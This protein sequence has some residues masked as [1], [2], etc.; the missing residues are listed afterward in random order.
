MAEG[1]YTKKR[2]LFVDDEANLLQGLRRMSYLMRAEW[3]MEFAEN[4]T[5]ALALLADAPFDI[6]VSDM[7]MP[8][9]DGAQLLNEVR[10]RYPNIVRIILSGHSDREMILRAAKSSHQYLA[11]PC[12]GETLLATIAR[13]CA[14]RELLEHEDLRRLVTAMQTLPSPPTLYAEVVEAAQSP[15]GSLKQ[16]GEIIHRDMSMTAKILQLVNSG[17]FGLRQRVTTPLQAVSLLGLEIVQMLILSVQIFRTFDQSKLAGLS[18]NTLWRHSAAVGGCARSIAQGESY[19]REMVDHAFIAGLLHDVG[20]VVLA[21]NLPEL[22]KQT[23]VLAQTEKIA[24]EAAERAIFN[25]THAEVGAYLLGL[26]GLPDCIV[27]ALA[28]HHNPRTC[29]H[30][31]FT[32]LTTVHVANALFHEMDV[33]DVDSQ[34]AAIDLDY[35]AQMGLDDRLAFWRERCQIACQ[36]VE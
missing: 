11:K 19:D 31:S 12:D 1:T 35:V 30:Q 8:G 36:P 21:V 25:T 16:I 14:L 29:L 3:D 7:R 9:I 5:Q 18:L 13:S 4:G 10:Q 34:T 6:I 23:L 33:V 24:A 20:K 2:V 32:L 17:F 15:H 27:E 22:Y 28:Y 26:W